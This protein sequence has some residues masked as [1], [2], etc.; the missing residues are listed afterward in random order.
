M[1]AIFCTV[2]VY[3][4][5]KKLPWRESN[6]CQN[7]R[8]F[9]GFKKNFLWHASTPYQL[10]QSVHHASADI[11][12]QYQHSPINEFQ[13]FLLFFFISDLFFF[14]LHSSQSYLWSTNTG[15]TL[16]KLV[17]S[18][19]NYEVDWWRCVYTGLRIILIISR[20]FTA[21]FFSLHFFI[22]TSWTFLLPVGCCYKL[23]NTRNEII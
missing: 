20:R 19:Y 18:I 15:V 4:T 5:Q 10:S 8:Y 21:Y 3:G 11:Y 13:L 17:T 12:N 14:Y 1:K 16:L 6:H 22:S 9:M 2:P 7:T 23:D